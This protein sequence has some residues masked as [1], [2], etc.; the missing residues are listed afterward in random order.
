MPYLDPSHFA[1]LQ[2]L[3]KRQSAEF[4]R[5]ELSDIEQVEN[6]GDRR[7]CKAEEDKGVKEG[8]CIRCS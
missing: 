2:F 8:H 3:Q 5:A 6:D 1:L 4:Y 7:R